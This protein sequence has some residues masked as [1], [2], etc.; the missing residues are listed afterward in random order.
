MV[1]L[2][3]RIASQ[4]RG[5]ARVHFLQRL[6]RLTCMEGD[7]S[8]DGVELVS[9]LILP[10]LLYLPAFLHILSTATAFRESYVFRHG[11]NNA[12]NAASHCITELRALQQS[13]LFTFYVICI[14]ICHLS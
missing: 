11:T 7:G 3:Q 13:G 5:S 4:P 6:V 9:T 1:P 2:V 12:M 14:C 10:K 8:R